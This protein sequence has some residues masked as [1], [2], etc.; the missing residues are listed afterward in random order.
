M[1]K[2]FY[3]AGSQ[4]QFIG[5]TWRGDTAPDYHEAVFRAFQTGEALAKN[6]SMFIDGPMTLAAQSLG[7]GVAS[8]AIQRGNITAQ[9]YLAI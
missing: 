6:L 7:N 3:M 8:N 5:V 9:S 1:F 4:A 2:R